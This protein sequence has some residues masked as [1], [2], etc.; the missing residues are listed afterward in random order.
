MLIG[1]TT[2]STI[3]GD[4]H[5]QATLPEGAKVRL[6][7][8]TNLPSDSQ[9]KFWSRPIGSVFCG[10]ENDKRLDEIANGAG[11]GLRAEDVCV[12]EPMRG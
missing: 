7:L 6:W 11:I 9:I 10:Q 12:D 3:H 8:A 4:P 2:Q 5:W 1:K